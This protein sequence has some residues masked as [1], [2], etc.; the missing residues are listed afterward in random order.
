MPPRLHQPKKPGKKL[1]VPSSEG[2]YLDPRRGAGSPAELA[3]LGHMTGVAAK[4]RAK[5][6]GPI[7]TVI[8]A[9]DEAERLERC[10]RSCLPFSDEVLVVDGG[11]TDG[12]QELAERLGCRVVFNE[13]PGY[14]AQRN[15][16]AGVAAHDW[17]FSIDSDEAADDELS[18]AVKAI[19]NSPVEE[20]SAYGIERV[21]SFMGAW[22]TESPE[23]KVRLYDRR[24]AAFTESVVHELVDVPPGRAGTLSGRVWHQSHED[25][26]DATR[27]LNL[28]TSLEAEIA[29]AE[30]PM[31]ASRLFLRPVLR[32]GQ[33]YLLRR[34]FRHGW[35]GLFLAFH[36]AYWELLREMKVYERR[37]PR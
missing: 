9:R 16:G 20:H 19:R 31:R 26:D 10:V 4:Q 33:R 18:R 22:L 7:S 5:E 36:W 14:S 25:L 1:E 28:Y 21:N 29:A 2:G 8:I 6:L 30:R 32:F 3:A 17:I 13:W 11:S 37:R 34:S 12:T 35:R 27:R 15:F 24:R 23:L